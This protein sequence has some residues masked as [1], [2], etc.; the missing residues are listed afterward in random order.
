VQDSVALC[1][2]SVDSVE[3][4]PGHGWECTNY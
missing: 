3:L 1:M 2:I 4:S